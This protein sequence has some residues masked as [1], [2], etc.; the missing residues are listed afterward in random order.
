MASL[1]T[2]FISSMLPSYTR[3]SLYIAVTGRGIVHTTLWTLNSPHLN[4]VDPQQPTSQHCGPSTAH[5]STLWTLNS[6]HLNTVDPQQ[7][8]SQHCGPST[9]HISTLWTL[10]SPHLSTVDPQQPTSQ[11]S[12]P[13]TAH[14]SI[15]QLSHILYLLRYIH[16]ITVSPIILHTA[17]CV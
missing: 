12:G 3:C 4:T 14:I 1:T 7:P 9:A 17:C 8:T 11:H 10:N 6:P 15:I 13:S 5:I 2:N 16:Q